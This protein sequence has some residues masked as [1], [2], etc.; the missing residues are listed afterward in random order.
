VTI[1]N[2]KVTTSN[3][4]TQGAKQKKLAQFLLNSILAK[5]R[6]AQ[7]FMTKKQAKVVKTNACFF[8]W[9]CP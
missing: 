8:V 9:S 5:L 4:L 7:N 3:A 6:N 2:A 1:A